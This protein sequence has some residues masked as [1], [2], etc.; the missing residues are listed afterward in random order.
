MKL[1]AV[2]EVT[3]SSGFKALNDELNEEIEA[4]R[5][6][7][8]TR[9]VF[10]VYDMNVKALR[11]RFQLSFCRLLSS[12]AKGF[13][14]QVGTE[15]YDATVAIMD[16][17]SMHGDTVV[18]PLNVTTHDFLVLLKEATGVTIIPSPTVEHSLSEVLHKINGTSSSEDRGQEDGSS[19]MMNTA[20]AVTAATVNIYDIE[21]LNEAESAVAHA[22]SQL[23]LM[24]ELVDQARVVAD[25]AT[26]ALTNAHEILAAA[27]RACMVAIDNVD[28][29]TADEAQCVSSSHRR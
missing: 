17:L 6:D 26:R 7:W 23:E 15:G 20:R 12:A 28:V 11:K 2:S 24:R 13:I 1:Q 14:A 25:E 29:A 9:F 21:Q 10:L 19:M 3:E 5:R 4:I 8:A 22:T 27:R 16:L 18:A